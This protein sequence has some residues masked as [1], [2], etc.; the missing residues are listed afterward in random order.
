M[1]SRLSHPKRDK[2]PIRDKSLEQYFL[3]IDQY[4]LITRK[5]EGELARR[6]RTGDQEAL[7]KMVRSNLRFVVTVAK[8]FQNQ[9]LTL[10]ELISEGNLG[11]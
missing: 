11:L 6:I 7:E 9:G 5:E 4:P 10:L 2:G 3:E 1:A 8:K